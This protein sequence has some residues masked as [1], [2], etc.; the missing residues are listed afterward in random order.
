[1]SSAFSL[2]AA[3]TRG[4]LIALAN[5]PVIV[6]DFVIES[7]YKAAIAV[8]VF[9]GAFMVAVLLGAD[10]RSLVDDG[11]LSAADRI[12]VPLG[13]APIALAAFLAAFG[14]V[15]LGGAVLMYAAK[16]GTLSVLVAAER[17]AGDLHRA[18]FRFAGLRIAHAYSPGAVLAAAKHF[19]RRSA[20]L[21]L[22]LGAAYFCVTVSYL[23]VV[24]YGFQW[25]AASAWVQA[26]PL[27]VLLAT[28]ASVVGVTAANLLFDLL[29]VVMVTDDCT[30]TVAWR[31][32]RTFLLAD[33]RQVLGI[34]G[35]MALVLAVA[36]IASITATA[37]LALVAWVP[38]AGLIVLPLQAAFW[39]VRGLFFQFT[40]M[41]TI[42]AYQT[43]YRRFSTP[44]PAPVPRQV[45]QA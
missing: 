6:I 27:L 4:A 33:A 16:A 35:T 12:L 28:S 19:W 43:Q 15:A 26:W 32:V 7:L 8:P 5:W 14:V 25:A 31:R 21:A 3:I 24:G 44:R 1:M 13:Q 30:L 9:G 18:P 22:W 38:L 42:S 29:R 2:R 45:Q 41:T 17:T 39:I 11:V 23:F 37:G 40:S 36:T 10:V 34:F 20:G